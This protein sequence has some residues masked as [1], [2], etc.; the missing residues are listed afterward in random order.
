MACLLNGCSGRGNEQ[1]AHERKK[2]AGGSRLPRQAVEKAR[3]RRSFPTRVAPFA[4]SPTARRAANGVR[5]PCYARLPAPPRMSLGPDYTWRAAALQTSHRFI[6]SL[7]AGAY[8]P[9]RFPSAHMAEQNRL[10][11]I[12]DGSPSRILSVRLISLGITTRPS[13]SILR[14]IP[15]ARMFPASL[16][17]Q[18]FCRIALPFV[19]A[20]LVWDFEGGLC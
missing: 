19:F 5:K 9:Q 11:V 12:C 14:T 4:Y 2:N 1:A 15:V 8:Q 16:T 7:S 17:A 20:W 3:L 6:D 13:S 18:R 10:H